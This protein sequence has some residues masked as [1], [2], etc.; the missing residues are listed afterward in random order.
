MSITRKALVAAAALSVS[1]ALGAGTAK[2]QDFI[3]ILTG[4]TSGAY[5]PIGVALSN[6]YSKAMPS[7]KVQVQPTKA[8]VENLNLLHGGKGE[9]AFTLGDSL[10]DAWNGKADAGFPV[11][12]RD[13]LRNRSVSPFCG[14]ARR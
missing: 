1:V 10:S 5:Y 6:V 9:I 2:A 11:R 8:S 4:G 12:K 14:T 3:N 7:A 13:Q